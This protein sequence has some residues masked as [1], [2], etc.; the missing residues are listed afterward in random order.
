MASLKDM[1]Q[2]GRAPTRLPDAPQGRQAPSPRKPVTHGPE[3]WR[4]I[5][6]RTFSYWDRWFLRLAAEG[7]DGLSTLVRQLQ[8]NRLR[9][10]SVRDDAEAK[11]S[12]LTDL[13]DRLAALGVSAKKLLGAADATNKVL[14]RK[15]RSKILEQ[16][17]GDGR[18]KTRP[19][20]ETPRR[21]LEERAL[22]G[23]WGAFPVS[24]AGFEAIL[25]EF[26]TRRDYYGESA[27]MA[28]ASR[29]EDRVERLAKK[30]QTEAERLA[31]YRASMTTILVVMAVDPPGSG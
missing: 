18:N 28:L 19:M 7:P 9:S 25:S 11:L 13:T 20:I 2:R 31:I 10:G 23:H 26:V 27:T 14:L 17:I 1:T 6:G 4:E 30:A 29:F 24:P 5:E 12:H 8:E 22:R 15:A 21:R 3:P 16:Q